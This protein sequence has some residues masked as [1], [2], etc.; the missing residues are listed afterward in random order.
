MIRGMNL[1]EVLP[2]RRATQSRGVHIRRALGDGPNLST[3]LSLSKT[4]LHGVKRH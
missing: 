1:T 4:S 2:S 3:W